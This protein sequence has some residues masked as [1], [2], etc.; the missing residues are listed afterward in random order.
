MLGYSFIPA[1]SESLIPQGD[2][3][4]LVK[5]NDFMLSYN[6]RMIWN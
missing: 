4:H 3:D 6:E 1:A 2:S 5:L